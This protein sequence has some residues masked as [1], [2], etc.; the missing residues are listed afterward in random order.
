MKRIFT[1]ADPILVGHLRAVLE[2]ENIG[3]LVKNEHLTGGIGDLP[4]IECWP[5]LWVTDD[6]DVPR[7]ERLLAELVTQTEQDVAGKNWQCPNCGET[8]EAQFTECWRCSD[9]SLLA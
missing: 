4:A 8:L 2:G 1:A 6:H 3:V 5:E 9:G 7:A